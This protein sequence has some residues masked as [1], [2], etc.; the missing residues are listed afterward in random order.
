[1]AGEQLAA[2]GSGG[3][4]YVFQI[5]CRGGGCSERDA[6]ERTVLR[7]EGDDGA[8]PGY[9]LECA[10]LDVLVRTGVCAEVGME[11][12]SIAASVVPWKCEWR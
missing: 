1:M 2:T 5:G 8:H 4:E 7:G 3:W 6:A 12:T 11:R 9:D 10:T